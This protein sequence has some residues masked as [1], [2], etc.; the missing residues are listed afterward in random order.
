MKIVPATCGSAPI[1]LIY[2][3]EGRGKTTLAAKFSKPLGMLLERGLPSGVNLDAV[4]G[5]DAYGAV[6]DTIRELYQDRRGYQTL[7][8]DTLDALE[9]MLLEHVCVAHHWKN[10]ESPPYGKGFVIADQEWHRFIRAITALRDKHGM[11]IV[12]V[13]HSTIER[14]DDPRAP[15]YTTYLPKLHK[16]ARH[17]VLDACD[18]IGFLAEDLG[19]ATDDGGFRERIRATSSNQRFLFVEGCP[20]YV[21]KNRYGMQPK[22]PIGADFNIS[23]LTKFWHQQEKMDERTVEQ[24]A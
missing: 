16:R 18:V 11:T 1:V 13:A 10:I 22:I 17:L 5:L 3:A 20:A 6:I 7:I 15:S 23:E 8:I 9:P 4:D 19:I 21:A 24:V 12:M 14:F 2:G